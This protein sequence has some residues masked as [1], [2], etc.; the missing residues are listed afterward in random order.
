MVNG[1]PCHTDQHR[2]VLNPA[3][4]DILA[5]SPLSPASELDKAAKAASKAFESWKRV[6]AIQRVQYLFKLKD[7]LEANFE[8]L[9]R[10]ITEEHGKTL[11]ITSRR[12]K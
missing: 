8:D 2:E 5:L 3:T 11:D 9:S 1:N 10:T 7:I 12:N 6:P 4:T